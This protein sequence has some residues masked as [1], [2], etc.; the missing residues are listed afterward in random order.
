MAIGGQNNQTKV[1]KGL[2]GKGH[3]TARTVPLTTGDGRP[4]QGE[5]KPPPRVVRR[6]FRPNSPK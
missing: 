1:K 5:L 3:K 6:V 4:Q 2:K